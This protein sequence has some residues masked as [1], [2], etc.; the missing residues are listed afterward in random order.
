M[1]AFPEEGGPGFAGLVIIA[2]K[3][4]QI[5]AK[6]GKYDAKQEAWNEPSP[7]GN[8]KSLESRHT[9][10]TLASTDLVEPGS[11]DRLE[12]VQHRAEE[13]MDLGGKRH[14]QEKNA[15]GDEERPDILA[16]FGGERLFRDILYIGRL[17]VLR[18]V[19]LGHGVPRSL[20]WPTLY[21]TRVAIQIGKG[22]NALCPTT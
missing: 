12:Q 17:L 6:V 1:R 8:E 16:F 7:I 19:M 4:I 15:H 10:L 3:A 11:A 5:P 18:R 21:R 22:F 13:M 14:A 2:N 9:S 20:I